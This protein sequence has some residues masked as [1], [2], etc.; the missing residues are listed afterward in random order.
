[1]TRFALLIS[2]TALTGSAAFAAVAAQDVDVDNDDFASFEELQLVA[3]GFT[4]EDFN[5]IDD[6]NDN[7]ISAQEIYDTDAQDILSRYDLTARNLVVVDTDRDGF[8]SYEEMTVIFEGL[9]PES[10]DQMDANNDNR[11]SQ[12]EVYDT[13]AQNILARYPFMESVEDVQAIDINGDNFLSLSELQ[14][15]YPGLPA[16][17]FEQM[18]LNGDSRISYT[19]LYAPDAQQIVSRY[20]S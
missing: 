16:E 1:M 19:E 9:S 6:N 14:A 8:A 4:Q 10:F 15:S 20:E 18:D 13:E 7:R 12:F 3:P 17:E 2:A 11:L 5:L